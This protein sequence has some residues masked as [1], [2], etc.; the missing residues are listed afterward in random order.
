MRTSRIALAMLSFSFALMAADSFVGTWKLNVAKSTLTGTSSDILSQT[1][2][3]SETGSDI[4]TII[5][6]VSKSGETRHEEHTRTVD[7]KEHPARGAGFK[8]E[9]ATE[10]VLRVDAST[11]QITAKRDGKVTGVITSTTSPDGKVMT[12][13]RTGSAGEEI[14]VFDR[15]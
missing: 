12:N 9:G 13:H 5:D 15:Q 1:M 14:L 3:I 11:H 4:R 7:G 10:T 8:L 6:V 2:T